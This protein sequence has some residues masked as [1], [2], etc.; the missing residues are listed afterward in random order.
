MSTI[1]EVKNLSKI[2]DDG[3]QALN[4]VS[5][6]VNKG[7]FFGV[8]G[9]SGSGKSTLLRCINRLIEPTAGQILFNGV[10]IPELSFADLRQT[11]R[12]IGMIFQHFNLIPRKSVMTNVLLGKLGTASLYQGLF[13]KFS[14]ED[15]DY[16]MFLLEIVGLK[17]KWKYRA[18]EMSGGQKQRIAIARSLM[19]RPD[20]LLADEPVASLD[21]ATSHSVMDYFEKVNKE[22]GITILCNLHFLSLVRRY[23]PRVIALKAGQKVFE[24]TADVIDEAWFSRIYGEDAKEVQI[25]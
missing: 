16:A 21:P 23:T 20:I 17:D 22:M 8:I 5:F 2:Y 24:G 6:S 9:L 7:D 14:Q 4:D 13:V 10:N 15:F 1:L 11:R 3:R 18:D 25:R 19:Q 12:K